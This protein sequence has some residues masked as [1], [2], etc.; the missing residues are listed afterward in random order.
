MQFDLESNIISIEITKG[1]ID[2]AKE[3][4]NFII[5][6]SKANKPILIEILDASKFVNQF[7][8]FKIPKNIKQVIPVN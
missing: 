5:H 2:H 3:I 8:K 1:K 7:D 4:G 6:V